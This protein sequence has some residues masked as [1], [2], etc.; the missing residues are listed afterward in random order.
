M[1]ADDPRVLVDVAATDDAAVYRIAENRALVVTLDFFTPIVDDPR[2]FGRIAAAN[3]LS[4]VYA[5]GAAP[6]FVL[7]LL[8]FPRTLLGEGLAEEII[9]GGAEKAAEAGVPVLGGHSVDDAEP[10]YGMVAVGEVDPAAM[11][12]NRDARAGDA[13]AIGGGIDRLPEA[14]AGAVGLTGGV[15]VAAGAAV[16]GAAGGVGGKVGGGVAV[17]VGIGVAAESPLSPLGPLAPLAYPEGPAGPCAPV[18]P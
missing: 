9:R 11:L 17:G 13:V 2:D 12:T 8:A 14:I 4:D 7:N 5:M 6:L 18:V 3:A 15:G 1:P 16:G 10:K